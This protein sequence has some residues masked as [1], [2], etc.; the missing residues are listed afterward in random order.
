MYWKVRLKNFDGLIEISKE[1]FKNSNIW[2]ECQSRDWMRLRDYSSAHHSFSP[3][4]KLGTQERKKERGWVRGG[5]AACF[6]SSRVVGTRQP[7]KVGQPTK[8]ELFS[9]LAASLITWSSYACARRRTLGPRHVPYMRLVGHG[10]DYHTN[11][12]TAH[13]RFL[14]DV[15]IGLK[16]P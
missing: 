5:V 15:Q 7:E 13:E 10:G 12:N 16:V 8:F 11:F 9:L 4:I 1:K 14:F 3:V 6:E 2:F